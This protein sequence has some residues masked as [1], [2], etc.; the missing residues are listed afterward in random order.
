MLLKQKMPFIFIQLIAF[1]S[2]CTAQNYNNPWLEVI[3]TGFANM[4]EV[5][6]L[7]NNKKSSDLYYKQQKMQWAP[8][9]SIELP[10]NLINKRGDATYIRGQT[11]ASDRVMIIND[12]ANI[13][14]GQK[15]PGN[16]YL[17]TVLGYGSYYLFERNVFLQHPYVSLD[18]S[19]TIA[20]GMFNVK[21]EPTIILAEKQWEYNNI[22][23]YQSMY[24]QLKKLLKIIENCDV[25]IAEKKYFS[26]LVT[27]NESK[28]RKSTEKQD[29][30]TGS[31][32]ETYYAEQ[33][34]L[35][36]KH[37]LALIN[38]SLVD[39]EKDLKLFIP[40]KNIDALDN[41]KTD[42]LDLISF[43]D[44]VETR[45]DLQT[46]LFENMLFQQELQYEKNEFNYSPNFYTSI[47]ASPDSDLYYVY[48]D[49]YKSWRELF[50]LP[51]P[52][53]YSLTLGV[54]IT[55]GIPGAKKL[56]ETTFELEKRNIKSEMNMNIEKNKA[57]MEIV[58]AE[59]DKLE[60]YW[61]E[62]S[63]VLKEEQ[64]FQEEKKKLLNENYITEEEYLESETLYS[65]MY[66]SATDTFWK[67]IDKKLEIYSM[68]D[69]CQ[70][71]IDMIG[72]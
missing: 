41:I 38:F 68:T 53:E 23:Y 21:K 52:L 25:Q 50:T 5:L 30:G 27:L 56:R 9:F 60:T 17:K 61:K 16:G 15:L 37:Q 40:N 20:K 71:I 35:S 11:T 34:L 69:S 4:P 42:L 10:Q 2:F 65:D 66:R 32:L 18:Y 54:K 48:S 24:E 29:Q 49:W 39:Y 45:T 51:M 67:I 14:I 62:L 55:F 12:S 19:Q 31:R 64:K 72:G 26:T 44:S 46:K 36:A 7:R 1:S 33:Q 22:T 63:E 70:K 3:D 8:T 43:Y 13:T 57:E 47:S 59:I 58:V 28:L 6:E